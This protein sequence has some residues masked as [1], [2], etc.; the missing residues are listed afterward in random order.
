LKFPDLK[1]YT[2]A[3]D[4]ETRDQYLISKGKR[5]SL[6]SGAHRHYLEGEESYILCVTISDSK[7]DY[8]FPACPKLWV[9]LKNIEKNHL[10]VTHNGLY[11][12]SWTFYEGFVPSRMADTMGLARILHEERLSYS[13]DNLCK[14]FLK[15]GK[16]EDE[17]AQWC[18]DRKLS[19]APQQWLWKMIEE[20]YEDLVAHYAKI[21]T[22]RTYD[23]YMYF[24]PEIE[25]QNLSYIWS[26]EC[27]LL[28]ILVEMNHRGIPIDNQH[29]EK[30]IDQSIVEEDRL[31]KKIKKITCLSGL[32][33]NSGKQLQSV[34]DRLNLPYKINPPTKKMIEKG[35]TEGNPSFKSEDLLPYG[36]EPDE[37]YLPHLIVLFRKMQKLRRDFLEKLELFQVQGRIH[38]TIYPWGTKTGRPTSQAP[39]IFQIPKRGKG[40]EICRPLFIPEEGEIF[41]SADVS[42]QELR[43][44][45]HYARG[46]SGQRYRD[47]Y[48]DES[49]DYDMHLD[50]A[51]TAGCDRTK[52]KSI[53]LG[54][55]FGM[56]Q[57][58]LTIALA[59]GET[60]GKKILSRFHEKNPSFMQTSKE[61]QRYAEKFGYIKTVSGRKRRFPKGEGAYKALNFLTQG[62][63]ADMAKIAIVR[64]HEEGILDYMNFYFWLYDELDLSIKPENMP[65]YYRFKEL[66]E[67]A[68]PLK[69]KI[70][71]E[72]E[73]GPS[74]GEIKLEKSLLNN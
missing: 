28:P 42:S 18:K 11:D 66:M 69:V 39:N 68:I 61:A 13:L 31:I 50:N 55:L 52:A 65:Y 1:E 6:G 24:I 21:D 49:R 57:K 8:Y 10:W 41:V 58:K 74:W 16:A 25:K 62:N 54:V 22:R 19:G 73:T 36:V 71:L 46:K 20:G 53:G 40:K 2:L 35:V 64:A 72:T 17:I 26:I 43:V 23:L 59:V 5:P 34:F 44:F 51:E 56:G 12:Y 38:P 7:N 15:I 33:V 63:S 48:N 3:F 45:A 60:E 32:N 70:K 30:M 14:D 29:R 37:H 27:K 4:I 9:W 67:T 47:A